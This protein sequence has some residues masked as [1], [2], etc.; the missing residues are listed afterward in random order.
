MPPP[1]EEITRL[2]NTSETVGTAAADR[3]WAAVYP[4]LRRRA[5]AMFRRERGDHTLSATGVVNEA[6]LRLATHEP[7]EWKNRS[8]FYAVASEIMRQVLIDHARKRAA[9][10][11]GGGLTRQS[12]D[13]ELFPSTH[14]DAE[15]LRIAEQA[16]EIVASKHPR[17]ALVVAMRVFGGL[18]VEEVAR[19]L[20]VSPRT[21][22]ADWLLAS[23]RLRILLAGQ[24]ARRE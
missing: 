7:K 10:K 5:S 14:D 6:Y 17:A 12:L 3:L 18:T 15:G 23:M 16:L 11:R 9:A 24:A 22:K 1:P 4:E 2:L 19:E 8:Q 13:E 21:V 20:D